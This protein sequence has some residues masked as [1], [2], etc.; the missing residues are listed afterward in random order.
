LTIR[1]PLLEVTL[2]LGIVLIFLVLLLMLLLLL[3][4]AAAVRSVERD[5]ERG[6][7]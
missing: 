7:E 6:S 5:R 1:C 2:M 3:A 4:A